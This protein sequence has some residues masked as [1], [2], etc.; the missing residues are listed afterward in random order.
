M[1]FLALIPAVSLAL[2]RRLIAGNP[3]RGDLRSPSL[4]AFII[5]LQD[6][7]DRNYLHRAPV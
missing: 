5:R 6:F 4:F 7:S 3:Y 1:I 2:N